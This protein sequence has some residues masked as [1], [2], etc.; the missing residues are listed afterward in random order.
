MTH[1]YDI[2]I[3]GGGAV[4]AALACA[5]SNRKGNNKGN[6]SLRIAV[7]EEVS[8]KSDIQPSYDD[9]GLS[10]SLLSKNILD[11][12]G[13][14][15]NISPHSNPVRNIH[16]SDQH[17]FGF[18]R[19]DA[20]SMNVPA[21]GYIVLARELGNA[22]MKNIEAADNIS[23]F[24]PASVTDVEISDSLASV[25]VNIK[26]V[27]KIITSKLLVAA[28]GADSRTRAMLGIKATVKDYEQVAIVSNVIP[29]RPH[30]DTAYERFTESGPLALLPY[31]EQ[32]CILVFTVAA[33]DAEHYL[34]MDEQ[35][36]LNRLLERFGRRLGK[37][38]KLGQRK[39]YPLKMLQAEEQV[40]HRAV[41]LGNAAHAVHPNA[42][43]GFNLGLRDAA[44]LAEAL[45]A[46]QEKNLDI[47]EV[48]ILKSYLE[49]RAEDQQRVL[50]F[51]DR[52]ARNFYN[53]QPLK[54]IARNL[55]MLATDL[56]PPLKHRF[57][58][59]AMGFWGHQPSLVSSS[60]SVS[61]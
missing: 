32:R 51:T 1:D 31:T 28:D 23:L 50:S 35:C 8:S 16:V 15:E 54:I 59:S 37:F 18:V 33:R 39:S 19:M 30:A 24:C 3:V 14:W 41:V 57:T 34:Q 4:G 56:I 40:K 10:I 38:S 36:F 44:V 45:I 2:I 7:I 61:K 11:N 20:K 53:R 17:H 26:G 52:L 47:G 49:S 9:R 43:Q 21:L 29:E 46:A 27:S 55:V 48:S 58:R 42:A 5:L 12:L 25:T 6:S 60:S 22:F 13:L